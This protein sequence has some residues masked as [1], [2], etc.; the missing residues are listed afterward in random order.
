MARP[1]RDFL[2][3]QPIRTAIRSLLQRGPR[4][5]DSRDSLSSSLESDRLGRTDL[6]SGPRRLF[7]RNV[8]PISTVTSAPVA[9]VA[10][11]PAA[12][13]TLEN[14]SKDADRTQALRK[15][16]MVS[17]PEPV[18][19]GVLPQP[20]AAPTDPVMEMVAQAQARATQLRK[21]SDEI[22]SQPN[23]NPAMSARAANLRT[24]A[25][26]LDERAFN[27]AISLR[28]E[29][30]A[31]KKAQEERAHAVKGWERQFP[32]E[33]VAAD[34]ANQ[35]VLFDQLGMGGGAA[36]AATLAALAGKTST[37]QDDPGYQNL[38]ANKLRVGASIQV[39][40]YLKANRPMLQDDPFTTQL[41]DFI[42]QHHPDDEA[43]QKRLLNSIMADAA[44]QAGGSTKAGPMGAIL[45]EMIRARTPKKTGLFW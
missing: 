28:N 16:E 41:L 36:E 25:D 3:R 18:A 44:Q 14:R 29:G 40:K 7:R 6:L 1:I 31:S 9:R 17:P 24:E 43:A 8:E 45:F 38:E 21:Q 4:S 15:Q 2:Q 34:A 37:A 42:V 11:S 10:P 5:P 22:Y 20:A 27:T 26:L 35:K 33:S 23:L 32:D 39:A 13:M 12:R 19:A 30:I